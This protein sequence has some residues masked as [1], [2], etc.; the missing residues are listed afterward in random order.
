MVRR[1]GVAILLAGCVGLHH[2]APVAA[3]VGAPPG[4]QE[5]IAVEGGQLTGTPTIQWTPGV[6]LFR[7]IPYAAPPVGNQRWRPPQPVVPWQGV[8]RADDFSPAC[9]QLPTSTEGN[10]WRE[11]HTPVSEDCLYLNIWTP[12]RSA[13]DRLPVMV[14]IHGGGNTRGAASENQY[15]G[16]YLAKKGVVFVSFNYRMNVFGFM[17][18]PE[19]TRESEHRS[20]GNY[21]LL[22]QI[23][24]LQWVQ[25]NI[26]RFGGDPAKV[27]LFGHSAGA[28]NVVSLVASPLAKGLFHRALALSGTSL[29]VRTTLAEAEKA[30]VTFGQTLGAPSLAALRQ[31][32]AEEVLKAQRPRMGAVVDGW[33]LPQD[34]YSIFAAGRQNKVPLVVGSVANDAPGAGTAPTAADAQASARSTYADRADRYLKLYP[35]TSDAEAAKSAHAFRTNSALANARLLARLHAKNAQSPVYWYYFAHTSPVPEGEVWDGRPAPSWGAYH[36]SELVYV[37]NAFPFQDWPWRPVDRKLGDTISS[38][39]ANFARTGSPNGNGLPEWPAFDPK[40]DVLMHFADTPKAGPAPHKAQIDFIDEWLAVQRSR[41]APAA[42]PVAPPGQAGRGRG[43]QPIVLGPDDKPIAPPAPEGFAT[44]R[45]GIPH[46]TI[47]TV[48]YE[49]K[50]VGNKRR[51]LVYIPPNYATDTRYPVLYLL[52]GIGGDEEEWRRGANPQAI[53]DNLIAD[54]KAVPMIV[55]MPNGRAQPNDRA[56]G[57]V[58]ATAPAFARFEQ[59]LIDDLIPFIESKYPVKRDRDNR[60]IAGLSMGGGQSLYFGLGHLDLFAWIGGFSS[61]PNTRMP[62]ELVPDPAKARGMLKLLWISCGDRDGLIFISQRTHAYLKEKN[63]PHLWHVDSGAHEFAVWKN[64]LY[65]F[66]QRIF[67]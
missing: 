18:H 25:R 44:P 32:S 53:L 57:N 45:E 60:A 46:G 39:W 8:K 7:G 6:R 20:S 30:G 51:A 22:D 59:D 38:M 24:A 14:W 63:V 54:K 2:G 31:K 28:S 52:H 67:R 48:E 23:A 61:A 55:V 12:A 29:A 49:S 58:M 10:A 40:L 21:A 17:A 56:E 26:A 43:G 19:L 27:M 62:E 16:A 11:G 47:D 35:A 33:V 65:L 66:A 64:D 4:P 3:I 37:F 41:P 9:M 34:V 1:L 5:P 42:A 50:T 15:D 13:A 36:G